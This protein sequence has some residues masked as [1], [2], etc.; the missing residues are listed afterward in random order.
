MWISKTYLDGLPFRFAAPPPGVA[1]DSRVLRTADLRDVRALYW[2]PE[3]QRPKAA[4]VAMHPRVDFTQHYAFPTLLQRGWGCLGAL[5]R[6]LGDD[7]DTVHEDL[8]LDVAACVRFLREEA[9]VE[10]VVLLGNSGGGSL[11]GYYQSLA[12]QPPT[13][14]PERTPGGRRAFLQ[15]APL[16]AADGLVL[17][18]AHRGQGHVLLRS[19]DPSVTDEADPLSLDPA[20]DLYDPRNGFR[21]SP[22]WSRYEPAFLERFAEGQRARVER[23]DAIARDALAARKAGRGTRAGHLARILVVYRTTANPA[24]VDRTVDPSNRDYGTLV[25]E[26]PEV[27]NY[28]RLGF[29]RVVTPEAW[30][31][32]WSGLSSRA[33]LRQTLPGVSVPV[34]VVHAG[35]DREVF[36]EADLGA[37]VAGLASDDR[38]VVTVDDGRHY[39]EPDGC[40]ARAQA[41]GTVADWLGARWTP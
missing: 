24:T 15:A 41:L 21:P 36:P 3:G 10:R 28:E 33:D 25:S 40:P 37:I 34:L 8:V 35:A 26:Q 18:A 39:F 14:R 6:N 13:S 30:L 7:T 23:I 38:T 19:I 2:T 5:S 29:A 16:P 17:L 1:V 27:Q 32:T 12:E 11:M 22:E 20:L 31:S 9:G 4:V